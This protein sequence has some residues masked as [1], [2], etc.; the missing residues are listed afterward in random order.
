MGA[1]TLVDL[2]ARGTQDAY[3][4]GNP[5]FSFYKAVY[6]RHTNFASEPIIQIFTEAPDFGK[7]ITCI[8]DKKADL[9]NDIILEV[10]LPALY[11]DISWV[12][13]I[14]YFMIDYV[15]LQLG[16]EKIDKMTGELMDAWMELST[17]IGIKN[18]L[19]TMIGKHITFNKN[20]Q[21]GILKL[22]IPLPFWFTRSV[23][24]SLPL[25]ALQR[26][27]I[28]II[29]QFKPFDM[30]WYKFQDATMPTNST[31]HITKANLI[32]NYVYLDTF[33]RRKIATQKTFEYLIE[34]YQTNATVQV[35]ENSINLNIPLFFN[36]P[37][38]ELIWMYRL[39]AATNNNDYYNYANILNYRTANERIHEPFNTL[40]LRFNG[41]DRF[42][43]ITSGYFYLYQPYRNHSCGTNQYIHMY[44]FAI[45]P[46]GVQPSGT[47][48]FSK[49]DSVSLNILCNSNIQ[50]GSLNIYALNYNILKIQNGMA[51]ILFS[52]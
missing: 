8:I 20:T 3:L 49:I 48:N 39:N 52:S 40:Q 7:K 34:Q 32:C 12:N 17:Q 47:C 15:E 30:C 29:I 9:V 45:N 26:T 14:G 37:V 1:G 41:N 38:K 46:E 18:T 4:I 6:R 27:D 19:Y 11:T 42:D 2:I 23:E 5:Q 16:G 50:F 31:I 28:K 35:P 51:G 21:T 25:I 22:L 10:E 36:H 24:R 43:H 13:G 44:S 33:E